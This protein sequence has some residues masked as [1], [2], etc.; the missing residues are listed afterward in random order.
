MRAG[1]SG[2]PVHQAWPDRRAPRLSLDLGTWGPGAPQQGLG[3]AAASPRARARQVTK[4]KEP[5]AGA[6]RRGSD[7][8][9][10]VVRLTADGSAT[11]RAGDAGAAAAAAAGD[12]AAGPPLPAVGTLL[13]F[14]A[15]VVL[16]GAAFAPDARL[17]AWAKGRGGFLADELGHVHRASVRMQ[18]RRRSAAPQRVACSRGPEWAV[19]LGSACPAVTRARAGAAL[20]GGRGGRPQHQEPAERAVP[21]G[22]VAPALLRG[23][24][25]VALT[26]RERGRARCRR[27]C[28]VWSR[29]WRPRR[30]SCAWR[31]PPARAWSRWR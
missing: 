30:P 15:W 13:D 7:A 8:G 24:C 19:Q 6:K 3:A 12:A 5:D 1:C 26:N 21:G 20:S 25:A 29:A 17:A 2:R 14:V 4:E 22:P 18:A 9:G 11:P 16:G 27:R 23:A 10:P 28:A 31:P